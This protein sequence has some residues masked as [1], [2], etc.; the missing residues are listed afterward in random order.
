ME[1]NQIGFEGH[2][3]FV[4]R[5]TDRWLVAHEPNLEVRL[6]NPAFRFHEA[7]GRPRSISLPW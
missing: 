3:F 4:K 6:K 2:V 5:R 1:I 7:A